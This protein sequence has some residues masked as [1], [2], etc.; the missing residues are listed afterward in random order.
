[1]AERVGTQDLA[2][3]LLRVLWEAL[4]TAAQ[5]ANATRYA[6]SISVGDGVELNVVDDGVAEEGRSAQSGGWATLRRRA[7]DLNGSLD[8]RE[9]EGGGT[10]LTWSAPH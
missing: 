9:A 10:Q 6:I 8:I 5:H 4:S 3:Q 7:E 2:D 1:V